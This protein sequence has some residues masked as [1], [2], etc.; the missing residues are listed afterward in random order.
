MIRSVVKRKSD[1]Q[2]VAI[3]PIHLRDAELF[4][5][6]LLAD[7]TRLNFDIAWHINGMSLKHQLSQQITEHP[8]TVG[9][10]YPEDSHKPFIDQDRNIAVEIAQNSG[11][12]W[13]CPH[14]ADETLE[15][16]ALELLPDILKVQHNGEL[17]HWIVQ[18]YN[19]WDVKDGVP[20]IRMDQPF[21]GYKARFYPT[22]DH[23]WFYKH[24]TASLYERAGYWGHR[25]DSGLRILHWGFQN[26]ESRQWHYK[27]WNGTNG[28]QYWSGLVSELDKVILKPFDPSVTH[29]AFVST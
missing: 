9:Y 29:E 19:V 27:R 20:I 6:Q 21:I 16:R 28:S 3:V 13:I 17:W 14:D 15:P 24:G 10:S 8:N 12:P 4:L 5:D 7:L 23:K 22:K 1:K 18:W 26:V 25:G 11:A 2:V